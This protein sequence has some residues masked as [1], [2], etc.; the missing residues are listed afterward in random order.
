MLL[1]VRTARSLQRLIG[2]KGVT[3]TAFLNCLFTERVQRLFMSANQ[4]HFAQASVLDGKATRA[5][6]IRREGR[7]QK[8]PTLFIWLD[9]NG[10]ASPGVKAG[11]H[12]FESTQDHD[13]AEQRSFFVCGNVIDHLCDIFGRLQDA[14]VAETASTSRHAR[15]VLCPVLSV[16]TRRWSRRFLTTL[17]LAQTSQR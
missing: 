5:T 1:T 11:Q 16:D 8:V 4:P 10:A 9:V 14:S 2:N 3:V 7:L 13:R 6:G 15:V 17:C 12:V